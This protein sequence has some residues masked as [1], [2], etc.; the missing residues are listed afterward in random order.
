MNKRR[1]VMLSAGN[2]TT[3]RFAEA[4]LVFDGAALPALR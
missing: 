3:L 1:L 2:G 4:I